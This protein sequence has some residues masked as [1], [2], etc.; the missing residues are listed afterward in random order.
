MTS[1]ISPLTKLACIAA[2]AFGGCHRSEQTISG[3]LRQRGYLWQREWTTAVV[4]ALGEADRRMDGV[5]ILGAEIN[6][7]GKKPEI[8]RATI[9][10]DAVKQGSEHRALAL[11]VA[12]FG[13]PFRSDDAPAQAIVDLA[14]QLLSDARAHDVNLEEFQFDFDCA[15]KN[16]GSYRTWLLALKPIVQPTRFVITVLPAW[17]NDSEF[18][19]LVHEVDGY[20]LQV[21]SV[22]ISAGTNA[23]LFDAQFAREWVR[24]AARFGTPFEVALPTYRCAAGYGPNGKLLSVAMDSVQPVWPPGTRVLEFGADA[25]EIAAVVNDWQQ[26]RPP[27][28]R[29]LIWYRIPIA[30]DT[31]N[32]RWATLSAVMSGRLPE[33][34]LN[35]LQ[36][37]EN[38]ID[39]SIF[40]AGEADEQ[41]NANVSATWNGAGLTA[42]DALA[43]WNMR[44]ENGRAIFTVTASRGLRLPPGATRK[45]GW[46]RFDQTTTLETA[47]STNK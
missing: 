46:L 2:I 17:L 35:I 16:L 28:L 36:E 10:W 21:H 9:D 40:N 12:P 3:P 31:R 11:R 29:E 23:K 44:S 41:L 43:G 14:K 38:P 8:F 18:R 32:W 24:K 47:L 15:Q 22:P 33:H 39:L 20:V 27:Q 13:G 45:I 25:N 26:T 19:K 30:T 4:D 34:K 7:A 42:S 6:L 1:V 5:V 37:G